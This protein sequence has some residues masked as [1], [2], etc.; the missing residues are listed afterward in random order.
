MIDQFTPPTNAFEAP[1]EDAL[2]EAQRLAISMEEYAS[3]MLEAATSYENDLQ[4][5]RTEKEPYK[6]DT[7]A[8][9]AATTEPIESFHERTKDKQTETAWTIEVIGHVSRIGYL[10]EESRQEALNQ[11]G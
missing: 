1:R 10:M 7:Q 11:Q 8:F 4:A 5:K 6:V 9:K 2:F 3:R